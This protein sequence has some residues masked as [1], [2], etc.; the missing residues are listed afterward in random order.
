MD[1]ESEKVRGTMWII[2]SRKYR[3]LI[4]SG[5]IGNESELRD[6]PVHRGSH[7]S[8]IFFERYSWFESIFS[9]FFDSLNTIIDSE[10]SWRPD[11]SY[12]ERPS[13]I[14]RIPHTLRSSIDEDE[15][16]SLELPRMS[17]IVEYTSI[18]S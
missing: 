18:G 17:R 16:T 3:D 14:T 8:L 5:I 4:L 11:S 6:F 13:H 15:I 9:N 12:Y 7:D 10:L 1:I 2:F